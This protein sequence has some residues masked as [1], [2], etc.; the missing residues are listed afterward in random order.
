MSQGTGAPARYWHALGDDRVQCD[1]CPR[2]CRLRPGQRGRCFVRQNEDGRLVLTTYG[3]SSGF[4]IDPVEKKPLNHV[5]A[6]SS[7][8]SFGTAG[9]NL[10]CR[11]CQNWE[12]STATSFD[13]LTDQAGPQ[14]IADA[15]ARTGCRGVAYTYNDPVIFP[16]YA[17]DVAAAAR[18]RGLLNIAVTAGYINPAPRADFFAAMDAANVDLKSFSP[19]FYRRVVGGRMEVVLDTLRYLVHE[20]S[21]WVEVTTLVIPGLNDSDAEL[22]ALTEFVAGELGVDVPLHFTAFHPDNRMM[23]VPRTPLATLRRARRI[24]QEAGLRYVYTGNVIDPDGSTTWC[25][26]CGAPVVVRAG[27]RIERY[28]LDASGRCQGCGTPVA[29]RWDARLEQAGTRHRI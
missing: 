25:P 18:A 29:G 1:L 11:F 24:G 19:D 15:A 28:A 5:A 8:F 12:I 4:C 7:V 27:Y 26:A 13:A 23:D 2:A 3:R 17:I 21:V 14:A 10:A 6:G 20:T 22:H 9:C 16:E